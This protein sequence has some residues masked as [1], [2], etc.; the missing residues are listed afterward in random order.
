M[1]IQDLKQATVDEVTAIDEDLQRRM[2]SN[3]QIRLQQRIDVNG[4]HLPDV[5]FRK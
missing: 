3:F 2:Y 5:I 1:T 4:G